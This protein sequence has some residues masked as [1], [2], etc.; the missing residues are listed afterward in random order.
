MEDRGENGQI[1]ALRERK[2]VGREVEDGAEERR[3]K[4]FFCLFY[5]RPMRQSILSAV[6]SEGGKA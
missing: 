4:I 6:L 2:G 5:L 1:M 3:C